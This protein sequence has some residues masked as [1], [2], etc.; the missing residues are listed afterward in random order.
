MNVDIYSTHLLP[1]GTVLNVI[2]V[3]A[4]LLLLHH[5][6][7]PTASMS[8]EYA[9]RKIDIDALDEDV[10]SPQD[11][12]DP[13]PRG[14]DG[15]LADAKRRSND[16]RGLVSKW[17]LVSYYL[18]ARGGRGDADESIRGDT[19]GALNAILTEPPYGEGVDEAK[20][21]P[22]HSL[23]VQPGIGSG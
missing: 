19:A 18:S 11:L 16:A 4:L 12:Y 3:A 13:D 20:V 22:V 10:L 6:H 2:D 7:P 8:S 17:V 23:I 9:F 15:V 5:T 1:W 14:P 21:R